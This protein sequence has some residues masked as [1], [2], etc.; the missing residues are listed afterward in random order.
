M[1]E[2]LKS[3]ASPDFDPFDAAV[4]ASMGEIKLSNPHPALHSFKETTRILRLIKPEAIELILEF[5]FLDHME[6]IFQHLDPADSMFILKAAVQSQERDYVHHRIH[7]SQ[8]PLNLDWT[9]LHQSCRPKLPQPFWNIFRFQVEINCTDVALCET[10]SASGINLAFVGA[11]LARGANPNAAVDNSGI[12]SQYLG[13]LDDATRSCESFSEGWNIIKL[14]V[15]YG[16]AINEF[17]PEWSYLASAKYL[18]F[19]S[20]E[21]LLQGFLFLM[22]HGLDAKSDIW[23]HLLYGLRDIKLHSGLQAKLRDLISSFF[24]HGAVFS[25]TS[26]ASPVQL[27]V[28]EVAKW[29]REV[30]RDITWDSPRV[31]G[32]EIDDLFALFLQHGFDPN[33]KFDKSTVWEELLLA[34]SLSP[35]SQHHVK[36]MLLFV[37]Y[38]ANPYSKDLHRI[39]GWDPR[40]ERRIVGPLATEL[41][42]AV[43]REIDDLA[44]RDQLSPH[45]TLGLPRHNQ[46]F[47]R[48]RTRAALNS[49]S[50]RS[51]EEMPND[52]DREAERDLKKRR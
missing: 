25:G 36:L 2:F 26:S 33:H 48:Y 49:R 34:I 46:Q 50:K 8:L 42:S 16:A 6:L 17:L 14:M 5:K 28:K 18:S 21:Q 32:L 29:A 40:Y 1:Q 31:Y 7:S 20:Q 12:F 37:R 15:R 41:E 11:L 35:N 43:H 10:K 23:V 4:G 30:V 24:R 39:L 3:R 38:R 27:L 19:E 52:P 47:R 51:A 22:E 45:E 13:I 9:L 44:H